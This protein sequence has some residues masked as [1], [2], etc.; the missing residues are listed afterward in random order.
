MHYDGVL[1]MQ[2]GLE[3]LLVAAY[4]EI[5]ADLSGDASRRSKLAVHCEKL[6]LESRLAWQVHSI[7]QY[8]VHSMVR[9]MVQYMVH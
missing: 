2:E 7:V 8:M 1:A 5:R 4:D 6:E 9:S 3:A